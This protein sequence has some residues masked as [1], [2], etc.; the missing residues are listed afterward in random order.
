MTYQIGLILIFLVVALLISKK[1][2][3]KSNDSDTYIYED[4]MNSD[5]LEE[6]DKEID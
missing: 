3:K 5:E 1:F 2:N 4:E 6:L